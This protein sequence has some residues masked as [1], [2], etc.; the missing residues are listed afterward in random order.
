MRR[1]K[2]E[3]GEERRSRRQESLGREKKACERR[4]AG[5]MWITGSGR[6]RGEGGKRNR[7]G[8]E[9]DR[10][11]DSYRCSESRGSY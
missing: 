6:E 9:Q 11:G 5:G 10:E 1:E 8:P 7:V 2:D 3:E 4:V